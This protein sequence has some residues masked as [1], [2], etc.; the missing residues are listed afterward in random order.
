MHEAVDA[1]MAVKWAAFEDD[2]PKPYAEPDRVVGAVPRPHPDTVEL[3][4]RYCQYVHDT[5]GRFPAYLDPMYQRLTCQAQHVDPD[6]YARYYPPGAVTDQHHAH[7]ERWHPELA[8][9]DGRPP[10]RGEAG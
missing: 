9:D 3:V 10:L 7:F 6:F 2:V 5:Y 8:G 4:K 1:F